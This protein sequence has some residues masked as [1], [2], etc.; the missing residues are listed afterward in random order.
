MLLVSISLT[1][2]LWDVDKVSTGVNP[3]SRAEFWTLEVVGTLVDQS[4]EFS[5]V[6]ANCNSSGTVG[7]S[8]L[9][10]SKD[11]FIGTL[12]DPMPVF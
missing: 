2:V 12:W 7:F 8:S 6:V 9:E 5:V 4:R 11:Y 1:T 3:S 10:W